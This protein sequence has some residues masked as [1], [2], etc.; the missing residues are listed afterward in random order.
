VLLYGVSDVKGG[1]RQQ[2]A[3][4]TR[5]RI[6]AAAQSL[7]EEQG[8]ATTTIQQI[9][10]RADVAWQTVYSVFGTK[11]AILSAVFDVSVAGDDEPVPVAERPFVQRIAEAPEPREK[12]RIFAAHIAATGKRSGAVQSVIEAAAATDPEIAGLWQS[13]QNQRIQGMTMAARGFADQGVLRPGMT[14]DRAR[15]ILWFYTGPWAYRAFVTGR[16]WT[17]DDYESWLAETLYAQLMTAV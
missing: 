6:L 2:R 1:R 4:E 5:R 13:L 3:R 7:F 10:E 8:Y 11:V 17:L 16:G 9:A 15:D 12:C 14:V